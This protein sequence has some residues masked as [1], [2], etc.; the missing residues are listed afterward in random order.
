MGVSPETVEVASLPGR[1]RLRVWI[2]RTFFA[3]V[4]AASTALATVLIWTVLAYR[5]FEQ[6]LAGSQRRLPSVVAQ[7][8]TPPSDV[9]DDPQV[10]LVS[11]VGFGSAY[12]APILFRTDPDRRVVAFLSLPTVGRTSDADLIERVVGATETPLNHTVLVRLPELGTVVDALGGIT[13]RNPRPADYLLASGGYLHFP[14][15]PLEL[16]G[17]R[18]VAYMK[19]TGETPPAARQQLVLDGVVQALLTPTTL[20]DFSRTA[21]A[22]TASLA[23]DLTASELLALGW[24]RLQSRQLLQCEFPAGGADRDGDAVLAAFLGRTVVEEGRAPEGCRATAL[25]QASIPLPPAPI[26]KIVT[27]AYPQVSHVGG[28]VLGGA[29]AL[30]L[31]AVLLRSRR[32]IATSV[33]GLSLRNRVDERP[34]PGRAIRRWTQRRRVEL[35]VYT[36]AVVSS[37]ALSY[38]LIHAI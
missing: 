4:L 35:F 27:R 31:A 34:R 25:Q 18:V 12:A 6:E 2:R 32:S 37:A 10:T 23:T 36:C 29:A 15:G 24:L 5:Q 3:L 28:W 11:P 7:T 8:L 14:S 13:I 9:F 33:R 38:L 1:R 22:M 19:A 30:A 20:A 17:R 21:R 26:A 16:D